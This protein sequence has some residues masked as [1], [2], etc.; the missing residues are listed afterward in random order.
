MRVNVVC[1]F[2]DSPG[3]LSWQE[4]APK[5]YDRAVRGVPLRRVGR[6]REDIGAVVAFLIGEDGTYLT[7]QTIMVDGGMGVF[8]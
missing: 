4:M 8:R 6:M 3:V 7:G 1:P 5:D 2:A